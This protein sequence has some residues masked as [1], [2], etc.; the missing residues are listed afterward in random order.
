M[1]R[2]ISHLLFA[3]GAIVFFTSC[4]K[5]QELDLTEFESGLFAR[6]M[7]RHHP[8]AEAL[9]SPYD[10]LY[11][12]RIE[13]NPNGRQILN[14]YWLELDYTAQDQYGVIYLTRNRSI[15]RQILGPEFDPTVHYTPELIQY[16][17][18]SLISNYAIG[19]IEGLSMMKEG[20]SL[21]VYVSPDKGYIDS[22]TS[23][24]SYYDNYYG[25]TNSYDDQTPI[26]FKWSIGQ[27][28]GFSPKNMTVPTSAGLIFDMR[29]RRIIKDIN[30]YEREQVERFAAD[31]IG[32]TDPADSI[33]LGVYFRKLVENPAG[34]SVKVGQTAKILYT[35]RFLD[36]HIFDTN[37]DSVIRAN[38][39]RLYAPNKYP[40]GD[41]IAHMAPEDFTSGYKAA[42]LQM[43]SGE[44]AQVVISSE[45]AY[46]TT[47]RTD[48]NG[49][50]VIPP[51]TP[52]RFEIYVESVD[53]AEDDD[54]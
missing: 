27:H 24:Y 51:R 42:L 25:Y 31:S 22:S 32:I 19:Q 43:K 21:R 14:G 35:G 20:D 9:E 7:T 2:F 1:K 13:Q 3:A 4:A 45:Q 10:G 33:A 39:L 54:E 36:G 11:V 12:N 16:N 18:S 8:E 47:G 6:W 23:S 15:A 30:L 37:V 17:P 46:G 48:T 44:R 40:L 29:L 5:D 26:G 34:D 50:M 28:Y 49:R 38:H 41:T 53:P 52:I